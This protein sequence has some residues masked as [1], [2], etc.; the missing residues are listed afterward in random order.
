V[1]NGLSMNGRAASGQSASGLAAQR[2]LIEPLLAPSAPA[3][4]R[5]AYYALLHD[6]RR[7]QLT[8]HRLPNGQVDG[9]VAVCQTGR[10]LFVPLVI[11]R[12][13]EG[14][15]GELL[16]RALA[17][18]RP[19]DLVAVS[20]QGDEVEQV[21]SLTERHTN[22]IYVFEPSAYRPVLNVMVQPGE[23]PFRY[24]VQSGGKVVSAAGI[25]WRSLRMAEMY[26]YS[27]RGVQSRGWDRAVGSACVR[28]LL[29]EGLLPLYTVAGDEPALSRLPR[30]LGFRDSGATEF[31]CRGQLRA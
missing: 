6:A 15:V 19:Y 11:V 2:K 25:N 8:L 27:E 13:R 16:R 3:D 9:F 22:H 21:M 18:G 20:E 28:A 29:D 14:T 10:D 12:A 5:A 4:A 1:S 31:E 17:P 23:G 7:V 24:E 30:S 26:V